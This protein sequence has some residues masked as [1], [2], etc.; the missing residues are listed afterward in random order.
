[1]SDPENGGSYLFVVYIMAPLV[2]LIG[3]IGNTLGFCVLLRKKM[4]KIGP[5]HMYR[6][7]LLMDLFYLL[8]IV[9]DYLGH[10]FGSQFNLTILSSLA[11]KAR[12]L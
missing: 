1:M 11:C 7:L 3:L 6:Y 8:Q 5:V 10:A 4:K 12:L 9:I 2:L